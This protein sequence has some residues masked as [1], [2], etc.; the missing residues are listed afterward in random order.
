MPPSRARS[1]LPEAGQYACITLYLENSI[2]FSQAAMAGYIALLGTLCVVAQTS[3]LSQ[4]SKRML[5]KNVVVVALTFMTLQL[6]L[7][8]VLSAPVLLF[9]ITPVAAL[10]S[11]SYPSISALV[12]QTAHKDQQGVVQGMMTGVR[13]LCSGLGP[14]MFGSLFQLTDAPLEA[15]SK[16]HVAI[17]PG[18]PFL[19]GSLFSLVALAV[20]ILLPGAA[21]V[22]PASASHNC[23][24]ASRSLR[25]CT[26]PTRSS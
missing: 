26:P 9:A 7:F 15:S 21:A 14:A 4:L 23:Q 25:R 19:V 11:M 1:Y 8:G 13:S 3:A 10:G 2:G 22:V 16:E 12:S 24:S 20:A 17:F 5:Q 18:S 6:M